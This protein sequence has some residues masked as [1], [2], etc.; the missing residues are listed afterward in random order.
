MST[1][2]AWRS[3]VLAGAAGG[4]VLSLAVGAYPL[5]IGDN[6]DCGGVTARVATWGPYDSGNGE[7]TDEDRRVAQVNADHCQAKA[8]W[9][10]LGSAGLGAASGLGAAVGWTRLRRRTAVD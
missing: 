1:D 8:R 2:R 4:L 6:H 3:W 5:T 10:L 9:L 7:P